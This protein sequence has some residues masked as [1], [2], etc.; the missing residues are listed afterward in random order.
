MFNPNRRALLVGAGGLVAVGV[1]GGA[2]A[3][4]P[5]GQSYSPELVEYL[6]CWQAH[7]DSCEG[8]PELRTPEYATWEASQTAACEARGR[9][10]DV[11]R[12]RPVRSRQDFIEL[13]I[14]VRQE[15]W[16]QEPDGT[17]HSHSMH[18]E[19]DDALMRAAFGVIDGGAY[20]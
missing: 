14:V 10:S 4:L 13:G 18:Y 1:A 17:W 6:R 20:V 2:V 19:L 5:S 3:A 7:V 16:H 8:E 12:D 11:I 15:F 9:A